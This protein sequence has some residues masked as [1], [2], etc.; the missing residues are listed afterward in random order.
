MQAFYVK[1]MYANMLRKRCIESFSVDNQKFFPC[2]PFF[3]QLVVSSASIQITITTTK[4]QGFV[5]PFFSRDVTEI[6]CKK[7][8]INAFEGLLGETPCLTAS[9]SFAHTHYSTLVSK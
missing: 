3:C 6:N 4:N 2:I 1:E 8:K 5:S 7:R 9:T